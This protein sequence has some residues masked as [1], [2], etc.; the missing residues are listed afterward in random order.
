MNGSFGRAMKYHSWTPKFLISRLLHLASFP[1]LCD[2]KSV[3]MVIGFGRFFHQQVDVHWDK[4]FKNLK[5]QN[6]QL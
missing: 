6:E 5:K 2:P 4:R 3:P 1:Y